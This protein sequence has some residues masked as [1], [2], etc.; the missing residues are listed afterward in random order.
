MSKIALQNFANL[1]NENTAIAALNSNN[2]KLTASIDD[3][4]SRTGLTPNQMEV[5]LDMN[6]NRII[7]LP[8]GISPTEPV[9]VGDFENVLGELQEA[10]D[11]LEGQ[12]V[13][14]SVGANY[15]TKASVQAATISALVPFL[16]TA[17]YT[18]AGDG[19]RGLY[20]RRGAVQPSHQGKIQSLDGAWWELEEK[21]PNIIQFGALQGSDC[22]AAVSNAAAYCTAKNIGELK[23]PAGNW[24]MSV[25][26]NVN[27]LTLLGQGHDTQIWN[28]STGGPAI[29]FG[30]GTNSGSSNGIRDMFFAQKSGVV[31]N[32]FNKGIWLRKQS[33]FILSNIYMSP[34][35]AA[36]EDGIVIEQGCFQVELN[37]WS[38]NNCLRDGLS[39][40]DSSNIFAYSGESINHVRNGI[41]LVD[42]AGIHFHRVEV[43]GCEVG[44]EIT[45]QGGTQNQDYFFF[46]CLGDGNNHYNWQIDNLS[47]G[48]WTTCWGATQ[49]TLAHSD[50]AG[51]DI[52][53]AN[54]KNLLFVNCEGVNNLG[55][56]W[57]VHD[58]GTGMPSEIY[59]HNCTFGN[60][61]DT[62][63]LGSPTNRGNGK[64]G[65][66]YGIT[67]QSSTK[68][69]QIIGGVAAFN[70]S[71]AASFGTQTQLVVRDLQGYNPQPISTPTPSGSPYTGPTNG[72]YT[73]TL[74]V[75]GGTV[76]AASVNG[77]PLLA[78]S[79]L[80]PFSLE[81][82][83][84]GN[85]TITYSV[86]PNLLL[87]PK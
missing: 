4:L 78:G 83:P 33:N 49:A 56:G 76:T 44:W 21:Y 11:I 77:V 73:S 60:A 35:P 24:E 46:H 8:E 74:Y 61:D 75:S 22:S 47:T 82:P 62:P 32:T 64:S 17:G 19:G 41:A 40:R 79:S 45:S 70:A 5:E 67:I 48:H 81:I 20:I 23:F 50:A 37:F 52:T 18:A 53:G 12:T 72:P 34:F 13:T 15:S 10:L 80:S 55:N 68:R 42:N 7:N 9:R 66:G 58:I 84:N 27:Q 3:T 87:Y 54:S 63:Y 14:A 26:L 51:W 29:A 31:P 86:A 25:T 65:T 30:D 16:W 2:A 59:W 43:G 85:Y 69:F 1:Q 6:S 71:G 38:I 28:N 36:L 57:Q 39:V